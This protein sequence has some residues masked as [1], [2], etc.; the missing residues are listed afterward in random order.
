MTGDHFIGGEFALG[1][2][3]GGLSKAV[4]KDGIFEELMCVAGQSSAVA[5]GYKK[6]GLLIN[7]QFA[8]ARGVAGHD[9]NARGHCF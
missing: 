2:Y 1:A 3:S 5:Y 8:R 6:T 4:G 7:H 9:W